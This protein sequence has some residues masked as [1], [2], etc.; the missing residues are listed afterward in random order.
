MVISLTS[1]PKEPAK[2]WGG[3]ALEARLDPL[4]WRQ[5]LRYNGRVVSERGLLRAS[6]HVFWVMDGLTEVRHEVETRGIW[7]AA[8]VAARGNGRLQ[9]P[10]SPSAVPPPTNLAGLGQAPAC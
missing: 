4:R 8:V 10:A 3:H 9:A 7:R 6:A 5:I 2:Q 1:N